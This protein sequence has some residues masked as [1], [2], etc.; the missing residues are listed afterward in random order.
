MASEAAWLFFGCCLSIAEIRIVPPD[1]CH[2]PDLAKNGNKLVNFVHPVPNVIP[3]RLA[4]AEMKPEK[5]LTSRY[6]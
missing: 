2:L 6:I 4:A 1:L 3:G 5:V